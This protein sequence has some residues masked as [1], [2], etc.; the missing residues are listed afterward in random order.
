MSTVVVIPVFMFVLT[1]VC[2]YVCLYVCVYVCGMLIAVWLLRVYS[3]CNTPVF[4]FVFMF[5]VC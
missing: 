2:L 5:V 4:M 1:H 3:C